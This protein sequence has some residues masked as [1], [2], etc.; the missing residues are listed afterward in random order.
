MFLCQLEVQ[1]FNVSTMYGM[2]N[3]KF[4]EWHAIKSWSEHDSSKGQFI[5]MLDN[6]RLKH[7][8]GSIPLQH[9]TKYFTGLS[10]HSASPDHHPLLSAAIQCREYVQQQHWGGMQQ[11][12]DWHWNAT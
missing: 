3:L 2:N 10:R 6:T 1:V 5:V 8:S 9:R 11:H 4:E 12:F 7:N